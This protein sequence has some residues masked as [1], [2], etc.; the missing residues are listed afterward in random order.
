[1]LEIGC[2][3]GDDTVTLVAA[4][5]AVTAFDKALAGVAATRLRA[6]AAAVECRDIRDPFPMAE[7]SA[8]CVVASLTLHYFPWA[9]T[10]DLVD[11]VRRTL[12]PGGIFLCRLN[13]T[14]DKHFGACGHAVIEPNYYLV[15]GQPKRFFDEASVDQLF[16]RGWQVLSKEHR[17]TTKYIH[18]KALWEVVLRRSDT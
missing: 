9:Q 10:L 7:G 3:M 1:V 11:R 17:V 6:P 2:G 13:S 14:H 5:L 8:G 18:K 16:A 15:D 4:D 12:Q